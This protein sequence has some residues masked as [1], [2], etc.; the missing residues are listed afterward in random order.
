MKHGRGQSWFLQPPQLI[1]GEPWTKTVTIP[2]DEV[3][4]EREKAY[5]S[6]LTES[7]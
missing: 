1:A 4:M 6:S 3:L 7:K 5:L 2:G